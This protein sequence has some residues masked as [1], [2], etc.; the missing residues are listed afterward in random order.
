MQ[1]CVYKQT[2]AHLIILT[3]HSATGATQQTHIERRENQLFALGSCDVTGKHASNTVFQ[4]AAS[5]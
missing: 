5:P 3:L 4:T 1:Y 2:T